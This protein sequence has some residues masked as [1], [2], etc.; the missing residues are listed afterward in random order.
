[1]H[2]KKNIFG[3]RYFENISLRENTMQTPC[4]QQHDENFC[5]DQKLL[6]KL[7]K[8]VIRPITVQ[9]ISIRLKQND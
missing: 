6:F 9:L 5:F 8:C 7:A 2:V 4:K 3:K 1:M